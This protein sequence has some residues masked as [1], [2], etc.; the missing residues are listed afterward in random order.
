MSPQLHRRETYEPA[1][2][3]ASQHWLFSNVK[4]ITVVNFLTKRYNRL[5]CVILL[6]VPYQAQWLWTISEV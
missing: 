1:N 2:T 5:T 3:K 6:M 4:A